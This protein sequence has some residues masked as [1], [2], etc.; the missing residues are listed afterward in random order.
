MRQS[1]KELI[2]EDCLIEAIFCSWDKKFIILERVPE[3][4]IT[5][6]MQGMYLF[7]KER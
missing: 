7:V 1:R 3:W 5:V 2:A 6:S 4:Y